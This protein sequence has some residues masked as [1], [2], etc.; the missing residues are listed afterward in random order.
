MAAHPL[1]YR[2]GQSDL[3]VADWGS[4]GSNRPADQ[5]LAAYIE[6]YH[7]GLR[8]A[9]RVIEQVFARLDAAGILEDALVI[10]TSDHGEHLGE[11]GLTGH[12][13]PPVYPLTNVPL[14]VYG[15]GAE[16]WPARHPASVVDVAPTFLHAI[17]APTPVQWDGVALQLPTQRCAVESASD[18][19]R[20]LTTREGKRDFRLWEIDGKNEFLGP[21]KDAIL[22]AKAVAGPETKIMATRA[23]NCLSDR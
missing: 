19:H 4:A 16:D 1:A 21:L 2:S 17:G 23:R 3:A 13:K 12:G 18:G 5:A 20:V 10:I 8:E 22:P 14:L 7:A 6:R 9:D 11:G 15:E